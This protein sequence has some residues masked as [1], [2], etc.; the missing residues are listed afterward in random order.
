MNGEERAGFVGAQVFFLLL[1]VV[2]LFLALKAEKP[3]KRYANFALSFGLTAFISPAVI[4]N[5]DPLNNPIAY[6]LIWIGKFLCGVA[7]GLFCIKALRQR[8]RDGDIGWFRP[9]LGGA[10]SL[11]TAFFGVGSFLMLN[12]ASSATAGEP[13]TYRSA[14]GVVCL[15]FPSADWVENQPPPKCQAGFHCKVFPLVAATGTFEVEN[16]SDF[17]TLVENLKKSFANGKIAK[18]EE[19]SGRNKNGRLFYFIEGREEKVHSAASYTFIP[20]K[21]TAVLVLVECRKQLV[22]EEGRN[23]EY[24]IFSQAARNISLSV[25]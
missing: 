25:K 19:L 21:K 15:T 16:E 11:L 14:D 8:R 13:W 3:S 23:A 6:H 17:T 12:T 18:T 22:S 4:W 9:V 20:E 7:G 1:C 5:L 2:F 24:K 10:L